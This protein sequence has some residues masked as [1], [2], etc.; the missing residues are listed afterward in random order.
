MKKNLIIITVLILIYYL[1][2]TMGLVP[3]YY[4]GSAKGP[5]GIID[6]CYWGFPRVY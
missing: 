4:C 3:G 2:Y 6:I 5:D 1:L